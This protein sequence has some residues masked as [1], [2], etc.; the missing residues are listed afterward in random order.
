MISCPVI[1]FEPAAGRSSIVSE[2][3]LAEEEFWP[4]LTK[5]V[6]SNTATQRVLFIRSP[7]AQHNDSIKNLVN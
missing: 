5:A 1:A 2:I 3:D 4:K 6:D 7:A